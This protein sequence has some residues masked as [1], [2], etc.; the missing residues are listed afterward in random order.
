MDLHQ[1]KQRGQQYLSA[2]SFPAS[3]SVLLGSVFSNSD[4]VSDSIDFTRFLDPSKRCRKPKNSGKRMKKDD[5]PMMLARKDE[6]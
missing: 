5:Q 1:T 6:N 2:C 3:S 4:S